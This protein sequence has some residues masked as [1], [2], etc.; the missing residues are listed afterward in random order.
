MICS[1]SELGMADSSTGIAE[2]D[3][4]A[5]IGE[6]IRKYLNLDDNIIELDITPNRGDCF[7]ILGVVREV[8]ANYELPFELPSFS[9]KTQVKS[10]INTSVSNTTA[11]PKYL[12]RSILG[13]DNTVKTCRLNSSIF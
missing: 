11:C 12:T 1:D 10:S 2:L 4:D 13:I 3:A 7:S 9:I 8:S 5:P 6:D